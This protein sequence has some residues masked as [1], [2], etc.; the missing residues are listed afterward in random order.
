MILKECTKVKKIM[1]RIDKFFITISI[2]WICIGIYG[3]IWIFF[4]PIFYIKYCI[5]ISIIGILSG[6]KWL[7][8]LLKD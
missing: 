2:I 8:I 6:T 3:L 7:N 5:L 1:N 4:V